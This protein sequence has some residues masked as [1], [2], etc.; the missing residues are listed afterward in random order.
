M[1]EYNAIKAKVKKSK[2]LCHSVTGTKK[3]QKKELLRGLRGIILAF[4]NG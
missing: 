2:F 3:K 4:L 1:Y